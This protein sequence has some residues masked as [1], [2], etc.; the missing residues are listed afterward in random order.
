MWLYR[1][2]LTDVLSYGGGSLALCLVMLGWML[3]GSASRMMPLRK[4]R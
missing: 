2:P 4:I 1:N 3:A